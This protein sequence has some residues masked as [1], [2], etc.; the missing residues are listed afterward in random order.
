M[1]IKKKILQGLIDH[2]EF[3]NNL[4]PFPV[5]D[6]YY[7]NYLKDK[8]KMEH[9]NYDE[10]PVVACKHCKNIF[11]VEDEDGNAHCIKC[12]NSVND[13]EVFKTIFDYLDK[14]GE[15]WGLSNHKGDEKQETG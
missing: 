2:I 13:L 7:L 9:I 10:E 14:Y 3:Y 8:L 5:F 6:T 15:L 4:A 11:I 12:R 1:R